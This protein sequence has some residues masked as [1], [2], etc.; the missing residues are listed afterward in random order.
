MTLDWL[1]SG[2]DDVPE[3]RRVMILGTDPQWL[4]RTPEE[5]SQVFATI[6]EMMRTAPGKVFVMMTVD[7]YNA[8]STNKDT[9]TLKREWYANGSAV[10]GALFNHPG[11]GRHLWVSEFGIPRSQALEDDSSRMMELESRVSTLPDIEGTPAMSAGLYSDLWHLT[12]KMQGK[13]LAK[14]GLDQIVFNKKMVN[15]LLLSSAL[16]EV[17]TGDDHKEGSWSGTPVSAAVSITAARGRIMSKPHRRGLLKPLVYETRV[18]GLI[19]ARRMDVDYER[20][21]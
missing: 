4:G 9:R 1:L 15:S 17:S 8:M 10:N 3:G 21:M 20:I 11:I 16:A 19:S 12:W 7:L 13:S 5:A 18:V 2:P 6:Q 14:Y